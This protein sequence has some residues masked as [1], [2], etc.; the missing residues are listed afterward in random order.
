ML[1]DCVCWWS[2]CGQ[3]WVFIVSVGVLYS[4]EG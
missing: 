2:G 1:S 3:C 4:V